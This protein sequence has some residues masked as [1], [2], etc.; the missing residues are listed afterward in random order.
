MQNH[1]HQTNLVRGIQPSMLIAART[2]LLPIGILG[3]QTPNGIEE[4]TT[5]VDSTQCARK[6]ANYSQ[7]RS[8]AGEG[9]TR[10]QRGEHSMQVCFSAGICPSLVLKPD[11]Y[12][13][14]T[15]QHLCLLPYSV[16]RDVRPYAARSCSNCTL[17]PW[18][19]G[20]VSRDTTRTCT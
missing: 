2:R 9:T 11:I 1:W 4:P 19:P 14:R 10:V 20:N 7:P 17:L 6:R 16:H 15:S 5:T 8:R 18:V 13:S 12:V 3:R